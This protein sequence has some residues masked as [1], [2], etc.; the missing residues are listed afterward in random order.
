MLIAESNLLTKHDKGPLRESRTP[1]EISI[2]GGA[3]APVA[4]AAPVVGQPRPAAR[5]RRR[6]ET[7]APPAL[8]S[9]IVVDNLEDHE[10]FFDRPSARRRPAE[11]QRF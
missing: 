8:A 3:A 1:T 4:A 6:A 9:N 5:K 10:V 7:E 2:G 11:R